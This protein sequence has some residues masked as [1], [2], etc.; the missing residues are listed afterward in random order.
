MVVDVEQVFDLGTDPEAKGRLLSGQGNMIQCPSCSFQGPYPVPVVYHD[1]EKELLL[2]YVPVELG[3]TVDGQER[4]IGPMITK[5]VDELPQ[6][7]RKAYLL[8]PKTMLTMQTMFETILEGD[9][10]TKE[11]MKSQQDRINL[12]QQLANITTED[13]FAEVAAQEDGNI[14]R[15][16]FMILSRL[17]ENALVTGDEPL[18]TR[19][20]EVQNSLIPLTTYGKEIQEQSQEMEAAVQSLQ[21]LG[22]QLTRDSLLD[23]VVKAPTD[24]RVKAFVTLARQGMDYQFFQLLSERIDRARGDGRKRLSTLRETLLTLTEEHDKQV[25]LQMAQVH[26]ALNSLLEQD[27]IRGAIEA[28]PGVINELFLQVLQSE[29]EAARSTGDLHRGGKLQQVMDI[30]RELSAPP[31]E[32][33]LINQL[34]AAPDPETREQMIGGTSPE[35]LAALIESLTGLVSQIENEED[36][37]L[38]EKVKMVYRQVLKYSM[39]QKIAG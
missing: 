24:I 8:Q 26:A 16:F 7:Q 3:L 12:L 2:T 20:T 27:D 9:G 6:E 14:D 4:V 15:E 10:I 28:N 19:L 37:E 36:P 11:M 1:P 23:L 21:A 29:L 39:R 32:I 35:M 34:I 33:E 38:A 13:T 18:A 22:E 31:P 30:I 17:V 25:E 5:I